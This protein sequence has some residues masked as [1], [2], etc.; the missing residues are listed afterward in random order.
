MRRFPPVVS[1]TSTAHKAG[2]SRSSSI[3]N[4]DLVKSSILLISGKSERVSTSITICMAP[5]EGKK[6]EGKV[7]VLLD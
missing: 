5:P 6:G 7:E 2:I 1:I 4:N 3:S